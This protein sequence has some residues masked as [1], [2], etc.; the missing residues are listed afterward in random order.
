[1]KLIDLVI[2][3]TEAIEQYDINSRS[4]FIKAL[5]NEWKSFKIGVNCRKSG[6]TWL[7]TREAVKESYGEK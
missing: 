5:K 6:G 7:V 3:S 2:T 1:M 4:N